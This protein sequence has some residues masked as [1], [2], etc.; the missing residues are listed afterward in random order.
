MAEETAVGPLT[1]EDLQ[2]EILA[3]NDRMNK[4]AEL[5]N[6]LTQFLDSG[7]QKQISEAVTKTLSPV[8]D[9][10]QAK[11]K[12]HEVAITQVAQSK[13][14]GSGGFIDVIGKIIDKIPIPTGGGGGT[15]TAEVDGMVKDIIKM[16][17]R[18]MILS[19]RK[20]GPLQEQAH[21]MVLEP[22][23]NA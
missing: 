1:A 11:F 8:V 13:G 2:K 7:L 15:F 16:D 21:V 20:T 12:E 6:Q 18:D 19:R 5:Q 10:I 17:L 3:L 14:G 9:A 4:I 23:P 22:K